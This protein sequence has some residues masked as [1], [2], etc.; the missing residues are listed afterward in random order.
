[1]TK[2]EIEREIKRNERRVSSLSDKIVELRF[3]IKATKK[4]IRFWKSQLK[5]APEK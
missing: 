3:D 4:A 1:M 2:K 5:N